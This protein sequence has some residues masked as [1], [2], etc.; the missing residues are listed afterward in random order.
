M[1]GA[2]RAKEARAGARERGDGER[3]K[4]RP[5]WNPGFVEEVP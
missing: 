4:R 1:V 3:V 5:E 2:V